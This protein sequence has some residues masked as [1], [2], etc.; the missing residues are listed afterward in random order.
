MREYTAR[1]DISREE[2]EEINKLFE[3]ELDQVDDDGNILPE[4]QAKIDA[5][6]TNIRPD[7]TP[8]S[9]YIEFE[10]G[11][12]L[13]I[14]IRCGQHNFYDDCTLCSR[15]G[16]A[17]WTFDCGFQLDEEMEFPY[18][19]EDEKYIVK[20]NIQESILSDYKPEENLDKDKQEADSRISFL[21]RIENEYHQYRSEIL[22][23][24]KEEIFNYGEQNS[25]YSVMKD[26]FENWPEMLDEN[27]YALLNGEENILKAL[28]FDYI[29]CDDCSLQSREGIMDF[30][31]QYIE[32]IEQQ[33]QEDAE[34]GTTGQEM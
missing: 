12:H 32:L 19:K 20:L 25:F 15:D 3:I 26:F 28:W 11:N 31:Y 6:S 4:M 2:F 10:N 1:L 24:S 33:A 14:H 22:E 5:C 30:L 7:T 34:N 27:E 8:Y 17:L 16:D 21:K 18:S 23:K 9:F 13:F 29:M